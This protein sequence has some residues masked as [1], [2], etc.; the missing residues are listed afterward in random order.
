MVMQVPD[1]EGEGE[2][3]EPTDACEMMLCTTKQKKRKGVRGVP[4][5]M[6]L[7]FCHAMMAVLRNSL[8]F[9]SY[10]YMHLLLTSIIDE[11]RN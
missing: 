7:N 6:H 10:T 9:D 5:Q 2:E 3:V 4:V 11:L 1:E 8:G